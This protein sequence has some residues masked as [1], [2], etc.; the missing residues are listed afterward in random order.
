MFALLIT[1]TNDIFDTFVFLFTENVLNSDP[2]AEVLQNNL[3]KYDPLSYWAT[4]EIK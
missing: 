3:L 4:A 1:I 2:K